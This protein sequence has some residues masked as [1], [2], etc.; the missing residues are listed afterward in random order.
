MND[1]TSI[2]IFLACL[3]STVGLLRLCEGLRPR[4][5]ARNDAAP[6]SARN[7]VLP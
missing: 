2:G 1:L 5:Q 6:D 7:G 3:F 4:E